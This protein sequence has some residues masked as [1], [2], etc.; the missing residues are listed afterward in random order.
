MENKKNKRYNQFFFHKPCRLF[1]EKIKTEYQKA[2]KRG[3]VAAINF[4]ARLMYIPSKTR[5]ISIIL[6]FKFPFSLLGLN[7]L[8]K[9]Y[10]DNK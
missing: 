5:G 8:R 3:S 7:K 6:F 1:L 2:I 9:M 10:K 4:D